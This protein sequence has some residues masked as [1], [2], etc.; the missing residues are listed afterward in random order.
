[1][2]GP[3]GGYRKPPLVCGNG[4]IP[5]MYR[6]WRA[7]GNK[8]P[9]PSRLINNKK[10][11]VSPTAFLLPFALVRTIARLRGKKGASPGRASYGITR[12]NTYFFVPGPGMHYNLSQGEATC[13]RFELARRGVPSHLVLLPDSGES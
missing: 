8:S 11:P 13:S 3:F 4:R 9:A 6:L 2:I 7:R 1:M 12:K 10:S 5:L